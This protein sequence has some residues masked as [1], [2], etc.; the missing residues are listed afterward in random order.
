MKKADVYILGQK[1]TIKGDTSEERIKTLALYVDEKIKDV[2]AKSPKLPNLNAVILASLSMAEEIFQL[3][4][5]NE[6]I[7]RYIEE[8]AEKLSKALD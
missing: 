8:E 3:R 1:Y 7:S 6:N 4:E 2:L 5:E